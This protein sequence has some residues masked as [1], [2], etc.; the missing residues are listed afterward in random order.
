[1]ATARGRD[2]CSTSRESQWRHTANDVA[3]KPRTHSKINKRLHQQ[4]REGQWQMLAGACKTRPQLPQPD[5]SSAP[6]PNCQTAGHGQRGLERGRASTGFQG[7]PPQPV[8]CAQLL[9]R[10]PPERGAQVRKCP[11]VVQPGLTNPA[12]GSLPSLQREPCSGAASLAVSA[13]SSFSRMFPARPRL[14]CHMTRCLPS[15]LCPV[16][17]RPFLTRRRWPLLPTP[18]V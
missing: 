3:V 12:L 8:L 16:L 17:S 15:L 14:G 13:Q 5:P 11:V 10:L 7:F 4:P 6:R 2:A 1:M 9:P 18:R